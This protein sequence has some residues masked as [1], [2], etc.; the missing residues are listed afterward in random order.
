[1]KIL[2]GDRLKFFRNNAQFIYGVVL[3]VLIPGALILNTYLILNKTDDVL[4]TELTRKASLVNGVFS[5]NILDL[6]SDQTSLQDL[7]DNT[8]NKNPQIRSLDVLIPSGVDYKIIASL[9]SSKIGTVSKYFYN[10]LAWQGEEAIA[11]Q[12]RSSAL[13]TEDQTQIGQEGFW[14][15]INPIT[16]EAGAKV[17]LVSLKLSSAITD[18]I[19]KNY[20]GGALTVLV[21]SVIIIILLLLSN[22]KLFR[23]AIRFQKL[24]E[25]DRMKDEFISMASHELRAPITGI[26]G[27]LKMILDKS[28]GELPDEV[29]EKLTLVASETDRL[30][31]LVEDL[32]EVSRIE[33]QRIDL[34]IK[35]LDSQSIID[36]M[37][38]TFALQAKEK[39]L[40]LKFTKQ[41]DLP[42]MKA[43]ESRLKQI[44]VNLISNAIKYTPQGS[45]S[46]SSELVTGKQ[47]MIKI[48]VSDTGLGMTAKDR[49]KLFE[50]FYRVKNE[51]TSGITGTGLGLWITKQLILLMK[52][53]IYVDS[54]ENVGTH[55]TI[56]LPADQVD[57]K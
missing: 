19:Y 46:L 4:N 50:K 14:V 41:A 10:T 25:V 22:M 12:T 7:V 40:E 9:D 8:V 35:S 18:D 2:S 34:N 20:V 30:H 48:K 37:I 27:Y 6:L 47:P 33:Q 55:V 56:L 43:D 13:S 31:D 28:F 23:S 45:V 38:Q 3:L 17:A 57:S 29:E 15:L 36:G 44:L 24:K 16:N 39:G 5:A 21:I 49:D 42:K 52:G 11:Y 51:K 26:R 32:L 1:M 54:I 53:D